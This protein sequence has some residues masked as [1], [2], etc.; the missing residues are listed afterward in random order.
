VHA[1]VYTVTLTVTDDDGGAGS[2]A[3]IINA[4]YRQYLPLVFKGYAP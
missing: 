4:W 1:G 3:A 2:D